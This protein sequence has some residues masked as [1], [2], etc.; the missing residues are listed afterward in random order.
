LSGAAKAVVDPLLEA[1]ENAP[2]VVLTDDETTALEVVDSKGPWR[3][4]EDVLA[5]IRPADE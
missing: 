1:L 4:H 3:T 2:T 5:K